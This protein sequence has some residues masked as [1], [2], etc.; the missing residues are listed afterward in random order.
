MGLF[1]FFIFL[2]VF[3]YLII[4]VVQLSLQPFLVVYLGDQEV[5]D[6]LISDYFV[7]DAKN[8]NYGRA[9]ASNIAQPVKKAIHCTIV[10]RQ[11]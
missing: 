1:T 2:I 7:K 6:S 5:I 10:L 4:F 8:S 3:C 9:N 11:V